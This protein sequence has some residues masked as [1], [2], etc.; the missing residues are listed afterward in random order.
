MLVQQAFGYFHLDSRSNGDEFL[1]ASGHQFRDG[2]F[3]IGFETQV[4]VGEDAHQLRPADDRDSGNPITFHQLQ[5]F[6]DRLG[7]FDGDRIGDHSAFRAFNP[8]DLIRLFLDGEVF[9]NYSETAFLCHADRCVGLRH[10]IHRRAEK[11]NVALKFAR[12]FAFQGN[13]GGMNLCITRNQK[14]IIKGQTI[15]N[16]IADHLYVFMDES[17]NE[18]DTTELLET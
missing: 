9:M 17:K 2:F 6:A 16:S 18:G 5:G 11:G 15:E 3:M 1:P 12:Q 4:T 14:N 7:G 8:I 13:L 10:R